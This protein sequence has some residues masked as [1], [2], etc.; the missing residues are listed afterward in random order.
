MKKLS[1]ILI[2]AIAVSLL[3]GCAHD[4]GTYVLSPVA[5]VLDRIQ[6]RG[7]LIVGTAASMPPLNMQTKAGEVIGFEADM[8]SYLASSMDVKLKMEVMPFAQLLPA[9]EKGKVDMVISG[10]TITGKRNTKVAFVGPYFVSGKAVL[11]KIETIANADEPTDLNQDKIRLT[12]LKGST[13]QELVETLIPKAKLNLQDS[14][15]GAVDLVLQD[16]VDAMIADYPFC[17]FSLFQHPDAG[18]ISFI[19]PFTFEPLG[20]ALPAN[21]PLLVNWTA[22]ALAT[23]KSSGLLEELKKHWF[24]SGPWVE[25]LAN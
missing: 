17:L 10:M 22:N 25:Q 5:P 4:S 7:E 20:I 21:D 3:G 15:E 12:A 11:T 1:V 6:K 23:L 13:S 9:L 14:Y 2:I 16:K 8:A 19:A 24:S 18:L